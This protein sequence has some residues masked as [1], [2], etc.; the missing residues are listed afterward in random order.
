LARAQAV[1]TLGGPAL[2]QTVTLTKTVTVRADSLLVE[3]AL[4][5]QAR[6]MT[7]AVLNTPTILQPQARTDDLGFLSFTHPVDAKP[8]APGDVTYRRE[9]F[10]PVSYW[11]D[12][13]ANGLGLSLIT[14][15]LQGMGGASTLET[16]LVRSATDSRDGEGVNDPDYHTL[17]Y[18]YLP[19]SGAAADAQPWQAAYA[20]NQPLIPVWRAGGQLNVGLPF[21]DGAL[22]RPVYG[23]AAAE[24]K[25]FSLA[26]AQG[27]LISDLVINDQQVLAQVLGYAGAGA[28][29][30][31]IG[32][33][34]IPVT[35]TLPAL[36]PIAVQMP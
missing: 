35:G 19:H 2:T 25:S 23:A 16:L 20:F 17:R 33:T 7:S 26:S 14:Q 24:P 9:I 8:I 15:G 28:V 12:V 30:V 5:I 10:Y 13:S 31:H 29:S 34:A 6:P 3:V 36:V 21:A 18:A 4:D 11:T 22:A 1:F 32:Q 27:G